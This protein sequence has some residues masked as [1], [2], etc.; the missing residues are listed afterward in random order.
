[1]GKTFKFVVVIAACAMLSACY[2][3]MQEHHAP[4]QKKHEKMHDSDLK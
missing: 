3:L 1:M 2:C 4:A